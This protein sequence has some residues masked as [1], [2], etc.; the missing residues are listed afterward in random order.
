M[1]AVD[2]LR[3]R[4]KRE[5]TVL[6]AFLFRFRGAG[7]PRPDSDWDLAVYLAPNLSPSERFRYQIQLAGGLED[8]GKTHIVILN[9]APPLLAHRAL[10][11]RKLLSREEKEYVRFFVRTMA[12]SGDEAYWRDFHRRARQKRIEERRFGRPRD[13]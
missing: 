9:D 8:F 13:S 3:R 7:A 11:G 5:D 4:L 2:E 6:F 12:Q 10:Q 1:N